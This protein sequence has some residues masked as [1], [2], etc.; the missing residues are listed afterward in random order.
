[1]IHTVKK[2][3]LCRRGQFGEGRELAVGILYSRL[4]EPEYRFT[5]GNS[6]VVYK[7]ITE[8]ILSMAHP[9]RNKKGQDIFLGLSIL[10]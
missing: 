5:I 9:W 4:T 7:G 10:S 3:F 2:P 8:D 6:R 1:M